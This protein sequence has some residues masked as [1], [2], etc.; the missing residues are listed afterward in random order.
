M[1]NEARILYYTTSTEM[2][3]KELRAEKGK[4]LGFKKSAS[5]SFVNSDFEQ[6]YKITLNM[7]RI[8]SNPNFELKTLFYL[9]DYFDISVFDFFKRVLSKD[10]KKIKEFLRLKEARKRPRKKGGSTK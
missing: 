5:Q 4:K 3:L 10:E 2:V 8:E 6:K 9:C 1:M 7:G